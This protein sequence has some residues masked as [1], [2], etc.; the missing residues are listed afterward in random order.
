MYWRENA[1]FPESVKTDL[2][3]LL[4]PM[5][6]AAVAYCFELLQRLRNEDIAADLYPESAK[7]KK[8]LKYVHARGIPYAGIVGSQEMADGPGA[9]QGY[10]SW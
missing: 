10:G 6:E 7:L 4:C 9:D 8:Q 1:L 3:L 2:D 5:D